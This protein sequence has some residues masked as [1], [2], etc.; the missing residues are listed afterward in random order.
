[1]SNQ[2]DPGHEPQPLPEQYSAAQTPPQPYA[3]THSYEPAQTY[4]PTQPFAPIPE[5]TSVPAAQYVPLQA[6]STTLAYTNTFALVS[7]IT[8]FIS[9]IAAVVFGHLALGQIKRNGDAG[10]GLALTGLIIGYSYFAFIA[11]FIIFYLSIIGLMFASMGA[12]MSGA[13]DFSSF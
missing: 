7:I 2:V 11:L 10:R 9:P 1:M 13:N 6:P 3:P 4:A 8:A 12:L 5:A